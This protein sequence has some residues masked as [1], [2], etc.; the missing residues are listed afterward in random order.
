MKKILL[1]AL[2]IIMLIPCSLAFY[3]LWFFYTTKEPVRIEGLM[4]I[5][6][7]AMQSLVLLIPYLICLFLF[8]HDL[9]GEFIILTCIPFGIML[10]LTIYGSV[11]GIPW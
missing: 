1:V 10:V 8:R 6:I 4:I 2:S 9:S 5:G 7:M 11:L 3:G